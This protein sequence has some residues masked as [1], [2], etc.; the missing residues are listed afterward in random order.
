MGVPDVTFSSLSPS[1]QR[2]VRL[3]QSICHGRL[4]NLV[5][6]NGEPTFDPPPTAVRVLKL[7]RPNACHPGAAAED[8]P[9]RREVLDLI[10]QVRGVR[11][12]T[13]ERLEV[14]NGM[15][16]L[17]EVAEPVAPPEP[18]PARPATSTPRSRH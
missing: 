7:D 1:F 18:A 12:G 15:P 3:M 9:V 4:R 11:N 6:R 14:V 17:A 10:A 2:L 16:Q 5:I 13:I 8:F